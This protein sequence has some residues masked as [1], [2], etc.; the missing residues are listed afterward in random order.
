MKRISETELRRR[1]LVRLE[2]IVAEHGPRAPLTCVVPP[3]AL[4]H[5]ATFLGYPV[6]HSDDIPPGAHGYWRLG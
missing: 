3:H 5:E 4:E 2:E 1:A 6:E